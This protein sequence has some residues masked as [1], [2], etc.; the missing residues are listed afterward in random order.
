M[1]KCPCGERAVDSGL[2]ADCLDPPNPICPNCG[3]RHMQPYP[4]GRCPS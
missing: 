4:G 3:N 2:C 1:E